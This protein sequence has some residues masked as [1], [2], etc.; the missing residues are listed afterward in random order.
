MC[1]LVDYNNKNEKFVN[2]IKRIYMDEN[3]RFR[4]S[5]NGYNEVVKLLK[6]KVVKKYT[7]LFNEL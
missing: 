5:E 6:E 3:H 7:K 2:S 4:L 1:E